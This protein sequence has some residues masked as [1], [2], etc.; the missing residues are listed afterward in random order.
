MIAPKP[1][2]FCGEPFHAFGCDWMVVHAEGCYLR[3]I[4]QLHTWIRDDYARDRESW[5]TRNTQPPVRHPSAQPHTSRAGGAT[6]DGK[7]HWLTPFG[8]AACLEG[9]E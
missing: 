7:Q 3:N 9:A 4:G 1:C 2:P 6:V 8:C 5:D